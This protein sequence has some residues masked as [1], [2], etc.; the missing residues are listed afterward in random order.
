[1]LQDLNRIARQFTANP[2]IAANA[3]IT[4]TQVA[5]SPGMTTDDYGNP[6]PLSAETTTVTLECYLREKPLYNMTMIEGV[7]ENCTYFKGRL[8]SPKTFDFPINSNS[9]IEVTVNGRVGTAINE[10]RTFPSPSSEQY[11]IKTTLGQ[12]IALI[13]QFKQGN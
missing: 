3:T 1:M 11:G 4:F 13:V 12:R 2:T 8:V 7:D 5:P 10:I 6:I 9:E